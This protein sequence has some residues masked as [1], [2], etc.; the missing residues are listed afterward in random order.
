MASKYITNAILNIILTFI[1]FFSYKIWTKINNYYQNKILKEN[2]DYFAKEMREQNFNAK[3]R[4]KLE[5]LYT[6]KY[7]FNL[8]FGFNTWRLVYLDDLIKM[9]N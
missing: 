8:S 4:R 5:T 1:Q 7:K 2:F 6:K 9:W 3:L